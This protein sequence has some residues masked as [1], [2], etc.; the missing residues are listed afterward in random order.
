[1]THARPGLTAKTG[2]ADREGFLAWAFLLPAIVYLTALVVAPLGMT[3][4]YGGPALRHPGSALWQE[5]AH[6]VATSAVAMVASAV[7]GTALAL[8]LTASFR[9]R[10]L[11][12]LL[13][14][15]PWTTPFA[16]SLI[17]WRRALDSLH[18]TGSALVPMLAVHVWRLTPLATV[19]IMA[20]L[21][22]IPP[23]VRDAA[24]MDG[25]GLLRRTFGITLPL[26]FPVIAV[27]GLTSA[28]I[29]LGDLAAGTALNVPTLSTAAY[30]HGVTAGD[31]GQGAATALFL[32]PLLLACLIAVLRTRRP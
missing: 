26:A 15:L 23:D 3:L 1:M 10:W 27:A 5:A 7:L 28:A 17:S 2:P 22:A 12:R 6:T 16:V 9:G 20:G 21:S 31:T 25:A 30:D 32:L 13:V 8:L 24:M 19:I 14:L 18:F 29:T 4:A 11:V